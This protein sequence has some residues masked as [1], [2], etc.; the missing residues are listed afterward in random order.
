MEEEDSLVKK[1]I[2]ELNWTRQIKK[3]GGSAH[4]PF[5]LNKQ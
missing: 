3:D 1:N 5:N 2:N 4:H